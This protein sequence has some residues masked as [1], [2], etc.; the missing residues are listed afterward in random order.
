MKKTKGAIIA[1]IIVVIYMAVGIIIMGPIC[2]TGS[3]NLAN[4]PQ[5]LNSLNHLCTAFF[6]NASHLTP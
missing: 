5:A 1:G 3:Q 6:Q 4:N 2:Q